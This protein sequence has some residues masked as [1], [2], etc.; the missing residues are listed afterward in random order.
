MIGWIAFVLLLVYVLG[1][2][3]LCAPG[4]VRIF[5]YLEAPVGEVVLQIQ[6]FQGLIKLEYRFRLHFSREPRWSLLWYK[7]NGD[8][9]VLFR[10]AELFVRKEKK[11]DGAKWM[12]YEIVK[13]A[14]WKKIKIDGSVGVKDDAF[15]SALLSGALGEIIRAGLL[16]LL[17]NREQDVTSV[18]IAPDFKRDR[19]R[20]NLECIAAFVPIQI[21]TTILIW[22]TTVKEGQRK[23]CHIPLKT[24]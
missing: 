9:K 23:S 7:E 5:A 19:L 16:Y 11:N 20:I 14:D 22:K 4:R 15:A 6:S 8:V 13:Y 2:L 18:C 17:R 21:I 12:F 3:V 10:L 24:L 1:V